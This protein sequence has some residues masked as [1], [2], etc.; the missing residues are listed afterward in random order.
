MSN[1]IELSPI[2]L[3]SVEDWCEGCE[4]ETLHVSYISRFNYNPTSYG[5]TLECE[6]CLL[7]AEWN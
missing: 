1:Q 4:E 5:Y 7:S 3:E 2:P 6:P